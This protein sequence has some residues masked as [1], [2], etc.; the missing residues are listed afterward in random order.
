M[1]GVHAATLLYAFT[2]ML[3]Q[4]C[5]HKQGMGLLHP[6][7]IYAE[8]ITKRCNKPEGLYNDST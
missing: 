1:S 7:E 4:G 3:S 5:F 2:R 6:A 8:F